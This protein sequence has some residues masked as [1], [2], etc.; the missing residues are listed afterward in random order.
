M[1]VNDLLDWQRPLRN[2]D[3][4]EKD[5]PFRK[6][7]M[8]NVFLLFFGGPGGGGGGASGH[9]KTVVSVLGLLCIILCQSPV[10]LVLRLDVRFWIF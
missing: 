5:E 6:L 10:D 2:I 1:A 9:N 8:L 3:L 4:M 7:K